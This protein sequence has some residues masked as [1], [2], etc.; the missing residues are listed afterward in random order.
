MTDDDVAGGPAQSPANEADRTSGGV[1]VDTQDRTEP[2][3]AESAAS[4]K[5]P[6]SKTA[7][8]KAPDSSEK[9][10]TPSTPESAA[11]SSAEATE[12]KETKTSAPKDQTI[13]I[14]KAAL[15]AK[16][17][18]KTVSISKAKLP[19][20]DA[21]K[22]EPKTDSTPVDATKKSAAVDTPVAPKPTTDK[23]A[24]KPAEDQSTADA[25]GR[26]LRGPTLIPGASV[27]GGRYRLLAPHGGGSRAE[28]LAG[29]RRQARPR[30]RLDVRRRRSAVHGVTQRPHS[31]PT[32]NPVPDAAP[33][34]D[35]LSRPRPG[36]RRGAR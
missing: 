6:E 2:V 25:P 11:A 31:G 24:E 4:S 8:P 26:T 15:A 19:V 36:A 29:P 16:P 28:V 23:A 21:S 5:A 30:G 10:S 7:D 9:P 32:G 13:A 18:D 1:E 34:S 33:R 27:A 14:S 35:Q 20:D 17:S 12:K 22:A 3:K